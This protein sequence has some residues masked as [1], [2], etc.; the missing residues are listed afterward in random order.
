MNWKRGTAVA[1]LHVALVSSLGAKLLIDRA[2][3]PRLWVKTAQVDPDL[4]IRG[5]YLGLRLTVNVPDSVR[6]HQEQGKYSYYR[7]PAVRLVV[8]D[9]KLWAE[10]YKHSELYASPLRYPDYNATEDEKRKFLATQEFAV[11]PVPYFIAE[12]PKLPARGT[13]IWAEVTVPK[14]GPPRPI[15]LGVVREGEF[16]PL[17][18]R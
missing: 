5:R 18:L 1:L 2:T 6:Y 10:D 11:G 16:Q 12:H 7:S 3:R 13:E 15:Q 9:G 17:D 8:R 4:P 14:N